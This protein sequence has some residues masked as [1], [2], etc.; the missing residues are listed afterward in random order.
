MGASTAKQLADDVA[1]ATMM[2]GIGA[3]FRFMPDAVADAAVVALVRMA[4]MSR[5]LIDA[6]GHV[7]PTSTRHHALRHLPAKTRRED[8]G[9]HDQQQQ[10]GNRME[11]RTH[12]A[13]YS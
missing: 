5:M 11:Q 1:R 9:Q 8:G 6:R 4:T 2:P 12:G 3:E 7:R 10:A 13:D